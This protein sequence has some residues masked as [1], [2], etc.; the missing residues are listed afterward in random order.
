[1]ANTK[2]S[3]DRAEEQKARPFTRADHN[4]R[5]E[6]AKEGADVAGYSQDEL[7]AMLRKNGT[8]PPGVSYSPYSPVPFV[9]V[10]E[11]DHDRIV[12][13][14]KSF[15]KTV[16]YPNTVGVATAAMTSGVAPAGGSSTAGNVNTGTTTSGGAGGAGNSST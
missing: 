4:E 3:D 1:M 16:S 6:S 9:A 15:D 10:T 12:E 8:V 7:R 13:S 14:Q 2:K 11:A 5:A